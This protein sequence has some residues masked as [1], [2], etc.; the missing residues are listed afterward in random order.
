MQ[1]SRRAIVISAVVLFSAIGIYVSSSSP[2]ET[3]DSDFSSTTLMI[4][5]TG[6]GGGII[7]YVDETGFDN[8]LKDDKSIGAMCLTG[9]CHY[10]EM[11]PT[12]LEVGYSWDDAIVTA[13]D[14]STPS[15]NDWMLPSLDAL[16]EICKF[17][18]GDTVNA[19]CNDDR[20]LPLENGFGGLS[21]GTYWSS[22]E[23][24]FD[25]AF[26]QVFMMG[27]QKDQHKRNEYKVRP[28]RAF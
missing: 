19:M 21:P 4:G 22:S 9:T 6:P 2:S 27:E 25:N 17:A 26:L 20:D 16:N 8:S 1:V 13:E 3:V 14:F 12:D 18:F 23:A 15:A 11:A 5:D 10:L 28:A 7:V 24:D